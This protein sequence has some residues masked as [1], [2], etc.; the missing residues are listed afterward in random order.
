[1]RNAILGV[2]LLLAGGALC[3]LAPAA[4][5]IVLFVVDDLGW[6]DLG[7]QGSDYYR[8]P[9]ID[10]LAA[11]GTRFTDAYSTCAVCSPSRASLLTGKYPARLLLTQWLPAGRWDAAKH[12]MRE[13]RFLRS[14]PLEETTLA[15]AFR[16][17]GYA[18]GHFGKWHLGGAPFSL[19]A[20]HG[21]D[22]NVGGDDHG[23]PGS[24]FFP[25]EGDW[26]IPTTGL[27]VRKRTLDGGREGD[28][29]TDRLA[30][31]ASDWIRERNGEPFF[32]YFP[33]YSVHTPLQAKP[34]KT[35][36]YESIPA[37]ERQ[38]KPAYAAMIESVDD[39]VGRVLETL[40]EEG[41]RETTVVGF[42]SDNG[43]FARATSNAPLRANK[44]SHYEGGIRVPLIM[45]G[46]G[47]RRGQVSPV[48]VTGT[49]L[50]PT[51]LELAGL[52]SRLHQHIDGVSLAPVLRDGGSLPPRDL[53]WHYPHYNRHPSSAPVSIIRRGPWKLIESLETGRCELYHLD[54]DIGETIDRSS[55]EAARVEELTGAL[56][57]WR[58]EVVAERMVPNR[59][60]REA[61]KPHAASRR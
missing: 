5:N 35:A 54:E 37:G 61:A 26:T 47:V 46:P 20:H 44:G 38:G 55:E 56:E 34:E 14:L 2:T 3:P 36:R 19:P 60:Y 18:T 53:F 16:E 17:A 31:A 12:R 41:L 48:P 8:T 43:G 7:C 13:G 45:A 9:H 49:D 40:G 59:Q 52:E 4:P 27:P 22:A 58:L 23:A 1:M 33:F 15:E 25:F 51:L 21:F 30:E 29:L 42:T 39:A 32:L 10:R 24:Y 50:Y 57:R 28:Y 6:R 11:G